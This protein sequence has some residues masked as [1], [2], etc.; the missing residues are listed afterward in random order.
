MQRGRP[1]HSACL[2][3]N[4]W[5]LWKLHVLSHC[6]GHKKKKEKT[7]TSKFMNC[8]SLRAE[9]L[10]CQT[11]SDNADRLLQPFSSVN[12]LCKDKNSSGGLK[13][14]FVSCRKLQRIF[15]LILRGGGKRGQ[16]KEK[17]TSPLM[18]SWWC[19]IT[20]H[21]FFGLQVNQLLC[22]LIG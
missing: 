3:A 16:R 1:K 8:A 6:R 7:G 14:Y 12:N 21:R 10:K 17:V 2:L 13:G 11:S 5:R 4:E 9:G 18:A 19:H 20:T 15:L 22:V